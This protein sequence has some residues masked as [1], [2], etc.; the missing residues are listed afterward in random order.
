M[1]GDWEREGLAQQAIDTA[2]PFWAVDV[3]F[4]YGK[5]KVVRYTAYCE[6]ERQLLE[7]NREATKQKLLAE[8]WEKA[9]RMLRE[10]LQLPKRSWE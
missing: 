1:N 4:E 3:N 10:Q 9:A 7:A 2:E 8:T 5:R 6:L